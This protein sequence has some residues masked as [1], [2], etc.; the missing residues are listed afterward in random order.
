MVKLDC[1][2]GF[3]F[4]SWWWVILL[5]QDSCLNRQSFFF[6]RWR[7]D[8]DYGS[9]HWKISY[10]PR[11]CV[12]TTHKYNNSCLELLFLLSFCSDGN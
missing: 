12:K 8:V 11:L 9:L 10:F 2:V 4:L 3:R 7:A 1:S 6:F 5:G